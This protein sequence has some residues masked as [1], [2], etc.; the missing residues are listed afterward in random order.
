MIAEDGT[1]CRHLLVLLPIRAAEGNGGHAHAN[2][3][4]STAS[5]MLLMGIVSWQ[6]ATTDK[7]VGAVGRGHTS[8]PASIRHT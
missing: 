7:I 8:M 5:V 3:A 6:L 1:L 4:L 2:L